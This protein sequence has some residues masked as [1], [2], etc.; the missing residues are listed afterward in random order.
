VGDAF[1]LLNLSPLGGEGAAVGLG[2]TELA[3]G[4]TGLLVG[5]FVGLLLQQQLQGTFGESLGGDGSNLL[6]GAKV[7]VESRAVVAEGPSGHDFAP[8]GGQGFKLVE[9][10]S[11]ESGSRHGSSC[12]EVAAKGT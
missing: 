10:L 5:E 9:F 11:G 12:L 4:G 7:H 8:L 3:A 2:G 6:E 1:G